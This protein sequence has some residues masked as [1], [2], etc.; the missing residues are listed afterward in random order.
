MTQTKIRARIGRI[1]DSPFDGLAM[2]TWSIDGVTYSV[3][4][5]PDYGEII[6]V[7]PDN[8]SWLIDMLRQAERR[9]N[10]EES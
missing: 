3:E 4:L 7:R 10:E 8:V 5:V 9:I 1:E 2:D 6:R